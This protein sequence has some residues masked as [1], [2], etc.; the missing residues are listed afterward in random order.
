MEDGMFVPQTGAAGWQVSNPPIFSL[1]PLRASLALF[2]QAGMTALRAKSEKL[3]G[4][5]DYLLSAQPSKRFSILTPRV[6][7]ER[8]CQLSLLVHERA[9]EAVQAMNASGVVCDFRPPNII[10]VAPVPLY[11]TFDDVWH[12]ADMWRQLLK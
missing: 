9:N 6:V 12:F 3:T 10:R 1:A 4:Y 11:N 7:A 2:D 5:L 8:G